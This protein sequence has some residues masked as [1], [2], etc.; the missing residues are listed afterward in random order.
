M[1]DMEKVNVLISLL[2]ERSGLEVREALVRHYD[3]MTNEEAVDYDPELGF[4]LKKFDVEVD[5]PF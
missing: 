5:I 1:T 4:L 3:F 2:E